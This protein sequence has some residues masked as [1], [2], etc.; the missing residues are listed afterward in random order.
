MRNYNN[1]NLKTTFEVF[2]NTNVYNQKKNFFE[3]TT[4]FYEFL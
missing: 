4:F 3:K 1:K 2:F